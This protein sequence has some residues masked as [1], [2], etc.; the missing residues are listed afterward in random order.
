[1]LEQFEIGWL[2]GPC[3]ELLAFSQKACFIVIS[4]STPTDDILALG[5]V[6]FQELLSNLRHVAFTVLGQSQAHH[7]RHFIMIRHTHEDPRVEE[8]ALE[9]YMPCLPA[10]GCTSHTFDTH[11]STW[12]A[13]LR[14]L[15]SLAATD[16]AHAADAAAVSAADT[17]VDAVE[18]LAKPSLA[19]TEELQDVHPERQQTASTASDSTVQ[20]GSTHNQQP[21][22]TLPVLSPTPGASPAATAVLSPQPPPAAAQ[23]KGVSQKPAVTAQ[24]KGLPSAKARAS[25]SGTSKQSASEQGSPK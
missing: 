19:Y 14:Q 10:E 17:E 23:K 11:A 16:D 5:P 12:A 20:V 25:P 8:Y 2:R 3:Q 24:D 7:G 15:R 4:T 13:Y 22:P 21:M 9:H 18:E 6:T 1:M